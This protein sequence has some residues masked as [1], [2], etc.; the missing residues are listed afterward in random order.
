MC[1]TDG[2][3]WP[4]YY[5]DR[6][7]TWNTCLQCAYKIPRE[8]NILPQEMFKSNVSNFQENRDYT[9]FSRIPHVIAYQHTLMGHHKIQRMGTT[10][11]VVTHVSMFF[12]LNTSCT[13]FALYVNFVFLLLYRI[14][15]SLVYYGLSLYSVSFAGN[16]Y[17]N[18]FLLS[19]VEIPAPIVAYITTE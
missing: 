8:R 18:F 4:L 12:L 10:A 3:R 9:A 19:L 11:S 1:C 16:K 7:P 14:A 2:S 5:T 17:F 15:A 6:T 13:S